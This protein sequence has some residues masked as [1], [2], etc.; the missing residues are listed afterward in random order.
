MQGSTP[1]T[2]LGT[3]TTSNICSTTTIT[4]YSVSLCKDTFSSEENHKSNIPRNPEIASGESSVEIKCSISTHEPGM[5]SINKIND[6]E[7]VMHS[8]IVGVKGQT[9]KVIM[10]NRKQPDRQNIIIKY[11]RC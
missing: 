6:T 9:N 2:Y 5:R 11:L 1:T 10:A 7:R 3:S 4:D 8:K